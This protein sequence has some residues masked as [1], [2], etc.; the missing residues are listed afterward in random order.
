MHPLAS[1]RA[2]IDKL[3]KLQARHPLPTGGDNRRTS[4]AINTSAMARGLASLRYPKAK[5]GRL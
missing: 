2:R 5:F 4:E 1:V 3:N